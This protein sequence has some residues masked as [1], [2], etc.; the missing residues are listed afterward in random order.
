MDR[1]D[2]MK[3]VNALYKEFTS[4]DGSLFKYSLSFSFLLA[5]APSLIIIMM[6]FK[7]NLL[8]SEAI[9]NIILRFLPYATDAETMNEIFD[10]FLSQQYNLITFLITIIVSFYLASRIIFSFLLISASHED[11]D[12]PKWAIRIRAFI[13]FTQFII[14]LVVFIAAATFFYQS[15]PIVSAVALLIMFSM[16][17]RALSFRKRSIK[18]GI[19]GAICSTILILGLATL[20][21]TI[22]IHFTSYEDIYGPLASLVVLLLAIYLISCIIYLGFCLNLVYDDAYQHE[23]CLPLK[24]AAFYHKCNVIRGKLETLFK[25]K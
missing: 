17:Y 15:L 14:L 5:L 2:M 3:K 4:F 16:A 20:F 11:V 25:R 19:L 8:P 9:Q 1:R 18:F 23:Q 6:L 10:F 12:V 24:H 22:I 13:L 21:I 7:F